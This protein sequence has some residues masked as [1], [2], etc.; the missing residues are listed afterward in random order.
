MV[1]LMR[2]FSKEDFFASQQKTR[3]L[4]YALNK[5]KGMDQLSMTW[6]ATLSHLYESGI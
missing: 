1:R 6:C 5:L 3:Q 2:C 4:L